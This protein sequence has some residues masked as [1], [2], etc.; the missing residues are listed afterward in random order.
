MHIYTADVITL[1]AEAEVCIGENK[2]QNVSILQSDK[3]D[4]RD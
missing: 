1:S 3:Y 4:Q 2:K